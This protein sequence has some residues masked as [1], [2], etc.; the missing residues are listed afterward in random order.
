MI[1]GHLPILDK[2]VPMQRGPL[3]Y[4]AQSAWRKTPVENGQRMNAD[5]RLLIAVDRVEMGWVVIVVVHAYDDT[6][7]PRYLRHERYPT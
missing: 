1:A 6:V 3:D 5:L 7:K 4:E 2:F